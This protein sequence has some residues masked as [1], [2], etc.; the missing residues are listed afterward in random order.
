M[1]IIRETSIDKAIGHALWEAHACIGQ[2]AFCA[3]LAMLRK[4]LDLWS[5]DYRDRSGMTFSKPEWDNLYWRLQKIAAANT[6]YR[7]SIHTIID[8]VRLDAN[9]AVHNSFV[10]SGDRTGT[11]DGPE[12]MAIREPVEKLHQLVVNLIHA[13]KSGIHVVYSDKACWRPTPP[14]GVTDVNQ[15]KETSGIP[16]GRLKEQ[17]PELFAEMR[18]DL[19]RDPFVREFILIGEKWSY[20]P[21]PNKQIFFYYFETHP[22]LKGKLHIL[23]NYGLVEDIK[24]NDVDRFLF[25]EQFVDYL[26]K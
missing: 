20:N 15:P 9:D 1:A 12:I 3:C 26:T 21:D 17:M 23:K 2:W 5:A 13:T 16:F 6:L 14:D 4:A 11:Y 18:E 10:C 25:T 24:F 19:I 7:D 8:G 22:N